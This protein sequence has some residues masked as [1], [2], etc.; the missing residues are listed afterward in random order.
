MSGHAGDRERALRLIPVSRETESRLILFVE[1][2]TAWQ[3][4]TNLISPA[5]LPEIWTRHVA[6]SLQLVTLV[7]DPRIIVDFG[8]GA[9]FPG[10]VMACA[11]ADVPGVQIHL[12]ESVGK[13]A[14]FLRDAVDAAAVPA[15]V[16]HERIESFVEHFARADLITARAV[17]PLDRLLGLAEPLLKRGAQALFHKGQD[18]EAE[19]TQA[20]KQWN[21]E[22]SLIPSRT[23]PRG[24]IV[25]VR[26]AERRA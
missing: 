17:A 5:T 4:T 8:S 11:L 1:L 6:D 23:D 26:G 19:L 9:G 15:T 25:F 13:K 22:A 14:N 3:K 2:L 18:V 24:R 12:V 16:H 21:I 7:P 20:S 10:L